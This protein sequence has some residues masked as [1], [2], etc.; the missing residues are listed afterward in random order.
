MKAFGPVERASEGM[1]ENFITYFEKTLEMLGKDIGEMVPHFKTF[2]DGIPD[3]AIKQLILDLSRTS[4]RQYQDR[5]G[6]VHLKYSKSLPIYYVI[7]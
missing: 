5:C 3:A 6:Q 4:L 2:F 7:M 1:G